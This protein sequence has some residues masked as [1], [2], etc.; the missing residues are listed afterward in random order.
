MTLYK[1]YSS[2][3]NLTLISV[4]LSDNF[5]IKISSISHVTFFL[6]F[7]VVFIDVFEKR[8]LFMT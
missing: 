8:A 6:K 5:Q 4:S 3:Q 1:Q 2:L 7:Q